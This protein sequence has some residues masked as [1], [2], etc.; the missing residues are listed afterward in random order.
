M[1]CKLHPRGMVFKILHPS[2][3]AFFKILPPSL[4]REILKKNH[5][6]GA[7][8][9]ALSNARQPQFLASSGDI[10][11]ALGGLFSCFYAP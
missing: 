1:L 9:Q 11:R 8:R 3:V 6:A 10:L 5:S 4:G 2:P 7:C